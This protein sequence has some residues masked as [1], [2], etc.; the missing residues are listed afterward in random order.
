MTLKKFN[1]VIVA[2]GELVVILEF[3]DERESDEQ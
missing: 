2:I 3:I 1:R